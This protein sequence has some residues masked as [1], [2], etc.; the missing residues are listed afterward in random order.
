MLNAPYIDYDKNH[1][2]VSNIIADYRL[3]EPRKQVGKTANVGIFN[4]YRQVIRSDAYNN[5]ILSDLIEECLKVYAYI[6]QY[7]GIFENVKE[8]IVLSSYIYALT[9]IVRMKPEVVHTSVSKEDECLFIYFQK[10]NIKTFYN[11]FYGDEAEALINIYTGQ[12]MHTI[13][14]T[15]EKGSREMFE[16]ISMEEPRKNVSTASVA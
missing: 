8:E 10:G 12:N 7:P 6:Q 11:L 5:M 2:V 14:G 9:S 1:P 3:F 16:I 15:V 13:E 4:L